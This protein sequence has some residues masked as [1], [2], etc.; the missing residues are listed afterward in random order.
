MWNGD[1]VDSYRED[2]T[3]RIYDLQ[4][5]WRTEKEKT[6]NN[7]GADPDMQG[8][9][10]VDDSDDEVIIEEVLPAPASNNKGRSGG[11]NNKRGRTSGSPPKTTKKP[12]F[13]PTRL[14]G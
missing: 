14:R 9:V 7:T 2:L 3:Q 13:P 8:A 11:G 4:Q 6:V 10:D 12:T 1:V 5:V